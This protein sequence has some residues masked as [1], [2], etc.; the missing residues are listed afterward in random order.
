MRPSRRE[1]IVGCNSNRRHGF[2]FRWEPTS[3]PHHAKRL[4]VSVR[5][6]VECAL[7]DAVFRLP[8][9]QQFHSSTTANIL[10]AIRALPIG[11]AMEGTL[12]VLTWGPGWGIT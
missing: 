11:H 12:R 9:P 2:E 6:G 4:A 1:G 8:M 7:G 10:L 5:L 3:L